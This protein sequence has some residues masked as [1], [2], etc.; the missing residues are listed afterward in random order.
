ML[1]RPIILLMIGLAAATAAQAQSGAGRGRGG[2]AGP[3]AQSGGP[4]AKAFAAPEIIGVI[5]AIDVDAGRVTIAYESNEVLNWP[6]GTQPFS[7]N[8]SALLKDLTVGEKVRFR[9]ES[10][11]ISTIRPL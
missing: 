6:E 4:G 8:K 1:K 2:R 10:Q 7:V 11:Q 3:S 5:K 9:L